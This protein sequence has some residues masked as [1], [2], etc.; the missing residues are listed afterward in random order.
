LIAPKGVCDLLHRQI[1]SF[2]S[3]VIDCI[4]DKYIESSQ[5]TI[6]EIY[7]REPIAKPATIHDVARAASVST[8]TVSRAMSQPEKVS[9]TTREAVEAAIRD[10]GFRLNRA[11]RNLRMQRA[12]AVLAMVHNLGKPFYSEILAG[13][14]EGLHGTDYALL[15]TDTEA[16][17]LSDDA[18]ANYFRDGRIDGAISLDG[19]LS[20]G[21]LDECRARGVEGRIVFLCEWIEGE[22]FP[23]IVV[24][25][26]DGARLAVRHLYELGHRRIAHVEGPPENVLTLSRKRAMQDECAVLGLAPPVIFPGDFSLGSGQAAARDLLAMDPRPTA[27][28]CSADTAAFGVIAGLREGGLSV[29]KDVSVIGFDDI[30]MAAFYDPALTTIRQE[31]RVL[32]RRAAQVL[33]ARLDGRDTP[34]EVVAV[35]LVKRGTTGPAPT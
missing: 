16:N 9:D 32:G 5:G 2:L 33:L 28:F 34:S 11:A 25:N 8:A 14:A 24:D 12:G 29:P 30:E 1:R 31:R 22:D 19:S 3:D 15:L 23:T 18:L 17:P 20:Q 10:T 13:L 26:A 7:R 4:L 27:V 21:A 35:T 6:H